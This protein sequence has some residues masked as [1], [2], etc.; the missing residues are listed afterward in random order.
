MHVS[1]AQGPAGHADSWRTTGPGWQ[2]LSQG[3]RIRPES[4]V[5]AFP[6]SCGCLR[7]A[8]EDAGR[9]QADVAVGG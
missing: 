7:L 8:P 2:G 6:C 4:G 3:P 5:A 9:P 1:G